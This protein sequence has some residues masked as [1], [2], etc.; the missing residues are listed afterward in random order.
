[1]TFEVDQAVTDGLGEGTGVG[2][3]ANGG[4]TLRVEVDHE[5]RAHFQKDAHFKALVCL[6]PN[7]GE[8]QRQLRQLEEEIAR[9]DTDRNHRM[10]PVCWGL[11]TGNP[12]EELVKG[13]VARLAGRLSEPGSGYWLPRVGERLKVELEEAKTI[14]WKVRSCEKPE[15]VLALHPRR[16]CGGARRGSPVRHPGGPDVEASA[17]GVRDGGGDGVVELARSRSFGAPEW[18]AGV[19]RK[20]GHERV[21]KSFSSSGSYLA[22]SESWARA[23]RRASWLR[24][25]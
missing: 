3:Q 22:A 1:M 18:Q 24:P 20:R 5:E 10:D 8:I 15:T 19:M 21:N 23:W 7:D 17:V 9:R 6:V 14:N 12:P 25:W 13:L 11:Y 16:R 4:V 2:A